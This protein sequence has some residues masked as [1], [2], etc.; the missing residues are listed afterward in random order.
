MTYSRGA[1]V[2]QRW[3]S[4]IA[5]A[6]GFLTACSLTAQTPIL[7]DRDRGREGRKTLLAD[8]QSAR[9]HCGPFYLVSRVKLRNLGFDQE[10][11]VPTGE[12]IEDVTLTVAAPQ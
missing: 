8:M 1:T 9:L 10:I 7:R 6:A 4:T 11:N 2:I 5:L 3:R 12:E